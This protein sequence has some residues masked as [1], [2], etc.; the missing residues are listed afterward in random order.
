MKCA[1]CI[2][3]EHTDWHGGWGYICN[4][5]KTSTNGTIKE[6]DGGCLLGKREKPIK[7]VKPKRPPQQEGKKKKEKPEVCQYCLEKNPKPLTEEKAFEWTSETEKIV[8]TK[9][10]AAIEPADARRIPIN[11]CPM[12]GRCL[13]NMIGEE[14]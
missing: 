8:F 3:S 10:G 6:P 7:K 12:C 1:D 11:F 9:H 2:F 4:N 14:D 13:R 5:T